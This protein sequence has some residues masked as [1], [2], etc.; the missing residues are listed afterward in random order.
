MNLWKKYGTMDKNHI[1]KEKSYDT[2][3]KT[4]IIQKTKT[5]GFASNTGVKPP[6]QP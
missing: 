4:I 3:S 1:T 6:L 2:I 5:I